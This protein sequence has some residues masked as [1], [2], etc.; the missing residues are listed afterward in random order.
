MTVTNFCPSLPE[1]TQ[2]RLHGRHA[3]ANAAAVRSFSDKKLIAFT[4]VGE[5]PLRKKVRGS[6]VV[7]GSVAN[8]SVVGGS[9]A[10]GG[11]VSGIMVSGSDKK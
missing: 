1:R 4:V 7:S 2:M 11:V 6:S 3:A 9:V 5:T 10:R 8:G